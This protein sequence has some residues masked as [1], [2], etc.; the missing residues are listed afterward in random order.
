MVF[1]MAI[2]MATL[3][4]ALFNLVWMLM[5]VCGKDKKNKGLK[6]ILGIIYT[7]IS[8]L[9]FFSIR[10]YGLDYIQDTHIVDDIETYFALIY[11]SIILI[12][13]SVYLTFMHFLNKD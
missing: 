10:K 5:N 3:C 7:I 2:N 13:E 6:I 11:I 4:F 9:L 8:V 1:V 12:A